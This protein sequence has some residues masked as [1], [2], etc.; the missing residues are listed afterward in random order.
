[1]HV[2]HMLFILR[3]IQRLLS[4]RFHKFPD[5]GRC[6]CLPLVIHWVGSSDEW[7]DWKH[8][9]SG[10]SLDCHRNTDTQ[11]ARNYKYY[12]VV[13]TRRQLTEITQRYLR[14]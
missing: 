5:N 12:P 8:V 1:M 9:D 7:G 11:R 4:A 10:G 6:T 14:V 2:Q 3:Q 13:Q